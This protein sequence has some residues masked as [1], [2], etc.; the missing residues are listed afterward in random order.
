MTEATLDQQ[1]LPYLE[2]LEGMPEEAID[3][4]FCRQS[5]EAFIRR[6]WPCL[7][8]AG[9]L[10]WNW[11]LSLLARELQ[12]C[13]ERIFAGL[14]RKHHLVVNVPFGSSKSSI[15][16]ILFPAWTWTR[17]P[18]MRH[19]CATHT[20][21]LVTDFSFKCR[22]VITSELYQSYFP[23]VV[24]DRDGGEAFSNTAGG[25]WR[26][27]T[28][29]GKTPTG[30]HA[31]AI[32]IDDGIDPKGVRSEAELETASRFV[33]EVI[34]SRM[35][36]KQVAVI[37]L[38]MQRLHHRDPTWVMLDT[39]MRE[40]AADVRHIC[41]PGELTADIKPPLE[42][43]RK[44]YPEAY[45]DDDLMDPVRL[46]R[47]V[48]NNYRATLRDYG[49]AGQ[50]LQ[51]P[52]P[53]GGGMF[54]VEWFNSRRPVAPFACRRIRAWDRAATEGA[55][56]ATAGVLL[57]RDQEG[58]YYVED[59]VVGHWEPHR[60]NAM[61]LATAQ[62]DRS[63]YGPKYDP[64]IVIEAERGSTGKE[65]YQHLARQLAGFR[66]KEELPTGS[67][68]SRAEPW[69]AQLAAGNV[70]LVDDGKGRWDVN[71]FIEQHLLFRPEPGKRLG[72]MKD[73]VD[74]AA[75][76][77]GNLCKGVIT[78]TPFRVL[79]ARNK[80]QGLKIYVCSKEQLAETIID[81]H[82]VLLI[83]FTDPAIVTV[84][85]PDLVIDTEEVML[86]E[87]GWPVRQCGELLSVPGAVDGAA[88]LCVNPLLNA[89]GVPDAI[90]EG[91]RGDSPPLSSYAHGLN[92]LLAM[93][94]VSVPD[95][96]PAELQAVW[97]EPLQPYDKLPAELVLSREHG[98]QLWQFVL[99]KREPK[100][101]VIVIAD[102]GREDRRGISCAYGL[103]DVLGLPR[104]A[105]IQWASD[106]ENPHTQTPPNGH[107]ADVLRATRGLVL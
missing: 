89:G 97:N 80:Y 60:R 52:V 5:F 76:A 40:G 82:F 4:Y 104:I 10:I 103:A 99:K 107:I 64:M 28:V 69:A 67:K 90:Q 61:I 63:R 75:M 24:L 94:T 58:F 42:E 55:G 62:R 91:A 9:N 100:P 31:H 39:A 7:P 6:F 78:R 19:I 44:E 2:Q 22:Q 14:P 87:N 65:A 25:E 37:M 21:T 15:Q 77:F 72:R 36:D 51:M 84:T 71:G 49:Y 43:I 93:Y 74:A 1:L 73:M 98:K 8:G 3:A 92:K 70:H 47:N 16:S 45:A 56:C 102:D 95:L 106:P 27:C 85:E 101:E 88:G 11:H 33:T 83:V 53:P 86:S 29:G 38:V 79:G 68:D 30:F 105:A 54:R 23:E 57:A 41:L 26:S 32:N 46:P 18:C 50:V 48:L 81:D 96:N 34:P 12:D 59:V 13:A 17:M 35:V 66:V 20:D